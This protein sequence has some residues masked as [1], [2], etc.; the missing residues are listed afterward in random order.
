MKDV[1]VVIKLEKVIRRLGFGVPLLLEG[2]AAKA[3]PYTECSDIDEVKKLYAED[4]ATYKAAEL[5]F[6]QEE[7][8]EKI[9]VCSVTTKVT[10]GLESL[11]AKG[12]RQLLVMSEG[13]TSEEPAT[14]EST[15]KEI[16]DYLEVRKDKMYFANVKDLAELADITPKDY[17]HTVAFYYTEDV[18]CPVAALVGAIAGK[19]VG[20]FTY[21]NQ[22][23]LGIDPLDIDAMKLNEIHEAGAITFV[24]KA[25]DNVTSEGKTLGGEYIDVVDS[26]DW[27]VQ[28][29]EYKVQKT[30]NNTDKVSYDNDGINMLDSVV[31]TVL[32]EGFENGMIATDDE[33]LPTYWT[34]FAK[35]S[36]TDPADRVVRKY[37]G[38]EF[39]FD[40][41]GAI[42][43]AKF[44]GYINI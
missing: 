9:A 28:Q 6:R 11:M 37:I 35:R 10:E 16:A 1:T 2:L 12:W 33:G 24:Q 43:E 18:V 38:G 41:A 13:K 19:P 42:H 22:I 8:P 30:F 3:V 32:K 5:I 4:T 15:L 26:K 7:P 17:E 34:D 29:I 20:S 25:G 44:T 23:L 39:G 21:K 31:V 14:Q 36:E 27:L 40:L